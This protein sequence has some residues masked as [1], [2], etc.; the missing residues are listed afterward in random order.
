MHIWSL[1]PRMCKREG[2]TTK[3]TNGGAVVCARDGGLGV[4]TTPLESGKHLPSFPIFYEILPLNI[5]FGN[6]LC[7]FGGH[8]S[9]RGFFSIMLLSLACLIYIYI[10]EIGQGFLFVKR[11]PHNIL[12][13]RLWPNN[14]LPVV[15]SE[16]FCRSGVPALPGT[17]VNSMTAIPGFASKLLLILQ[18]WL[19]FLAAAETLWQCCSWKRI[20]EAHAWRLWTVAILIHVSWSSN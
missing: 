3:R 14:L 19:M 8:A 18:F 6:S 2:Q 4:Q 15:K 5:W 12:R 7:N 17:D 10:R 13:H 1:T 9:A 20:S 11:F 16:N